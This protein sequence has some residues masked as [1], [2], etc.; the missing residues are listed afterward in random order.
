MNAYIQVITTTATQGEAEAIARALVEQRQAACVQIVGPIT[1]IYRWQGQVERGEEWQ[2][3]IKSRG[4]LF[5]QIAATIRSLHPYQVPEII[6][7]PIEAGSD[8]YL[9]WIAGETEQK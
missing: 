9:H 4:A 8:S 3:H 1:S 5:N 7:L 2:C 6:A